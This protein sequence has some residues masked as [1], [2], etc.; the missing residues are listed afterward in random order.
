M[1]KET[2]YKIVLLISGVLFALLI[3]EVFCRVGGRY[4]TFAEQCTGKPYFSLYE[5]HTYGW[6]RVMPPSMTME[7]NTKEFNYKVSSNSLGLPDREYSLSKAPHSLRIA[8]F[9]DSF[10]EG[11]GA[12]ADSSWPRLLQTLLSKTDTD[13]VEVMNCGISGSDPVYEYML[14]KKKILQY[15]PDMVIVAINRT[16]I[17]DCIVRGGFERFRPD[18][19]VRYVDPPWWEYIYAHSFL[20]RTIIGS[21]LHYNYLLLSRTEF[22]ARHQKAIQILEQATDSISALCQQNNCR[23]IFVFHPIGQDLPENRMETQPILDYARTKGFT[24]VNI[25]NYF[26]NNG[27]NISTSDKYYWPIDGHNKPSGYLLIARALAEQIERD[28]A[29]SP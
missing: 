7:N 16:D 15:H 21:G 17:E 20:F 3:G 1:T 8:A 14:L 29:I 2:K 13:S 28:Q 26:V 27:V 9:G 10:T 12:V 22:K 18:S 4:L 5:A 23:L 11:F 6:L 24:T 25:L 19:T